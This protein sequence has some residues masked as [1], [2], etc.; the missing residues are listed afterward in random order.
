MAKSEHEGSLQPRLWLLPLDSSHYNGVS[1]RVRHEKT[2]N[3]TDGSPTLKDSP[4]RDTEHVECQLCGS[5]NLSLTQVPFG[6]VDVHLGNNTS[7]IQCYLSTYYAPSSRFG[8]SLELF[9]F[10]LTGTL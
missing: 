9:L 3:T 1:Q 2:K 10:I 8:A 5:V 4:Q 7:N 6:P